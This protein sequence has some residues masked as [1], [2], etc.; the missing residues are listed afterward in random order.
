MN[1]E[2]ENNVLKQKIE[3]LE[4]HIA[5]LKNIWKNIP[6]IAGLIQKN[7]YKIEKYKYKVLY[8]KTCRQSSDHTKQK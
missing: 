7:N 6:F 4:K 5:E 3:G 8:N 2:E 1:A